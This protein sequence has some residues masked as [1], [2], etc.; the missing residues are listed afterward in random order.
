[1][2]PQDGPTASGQHTKYTARAPEKSQIEVRQRA[3][4]VFLVFR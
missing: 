2:Q 1:M 4:L 3:F